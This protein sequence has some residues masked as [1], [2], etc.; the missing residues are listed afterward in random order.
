MLSNAFLDNLIL[1]TGHN[2]VFIATRMMGLMEFEDHSELSREAQLE[3][4]R[5]R[6]PGVYDEG[7]S[8]M[9]LAVYDYARNLVGLSNLNDIGKDWVLSQLPLKL[10][11][12]ME[13]CEG[14][15]GS[16]LTTMVHRTVVNTIINF[17]RDTGK[18]D[19]AVLDVEDHFSDDVAFS[20]GSYVD[21]V[22]ERR[23]DRKLLADGLGQAMQKLSPEHREVLEMFHF[24]GLSC[25][26]IA[27]RIGV[28]EGT[29]RS[30]KFYGGESLKGHLLG[31]GKFQELA[32]LV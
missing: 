4:L 21:P 5:N 7:F 16:L 19:G 17:R 28:S 11:K 27:E 12:C 9:Y 23:F 6:R 13:T 31:S 2:N 32:E 26:E 18:I 14:R 10:K 29:V 15:N 24:E 22:Q 8:K 3:F 20:N 1:V 30:R 25:V